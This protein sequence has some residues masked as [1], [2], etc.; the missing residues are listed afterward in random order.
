[1][2]YS[3]EWYSTYAMVGACMHADNGW[4]WSLCSVYFSVFL[5]LV[6]SKPGISDT[7][8]SLAENEIC[9]WIYTKEWMRPSIMYCFSFDMIMI[10]C[11]VNFLSLQI[12]TTT[13]TN[14]EPM[15][16]SFTDFDVWTNSDAELTSWS[17]NECSF[18]LY[19]CAP[20]ELSLMN[21][22]ILH[23]DLVLC[24]YMC[25]VTLGL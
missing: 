23:K 22:I 19:G 1:M 17:S 24:W 2:S 9:L 4:W 6:Y 8:Q 11:F 15:Y 16:I 13:I 21:D 10:P 7:W 18:C 25:Y 14:D 20:F 3:N 5:L 12:I